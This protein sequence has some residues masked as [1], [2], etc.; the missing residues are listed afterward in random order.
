MALGHRKWCIPDMYMV[1][2]DPNRDTPSH[3]TVCFFNGG[4]NT[5]NV[6]ITLYFEEDE[7]ENYGERNIK[8][9]I[10]PHSSTHFRMDKYEVQGYAIPRNTSYSAIINSTE[11]IV[12]EY[13]RLNWIDGLMQSFAIIPYYEE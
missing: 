3:E 2:N 9:E 7:E 4:E 6:A 1:E 5:A 11:N 13:A 8:L 10:A 12:V